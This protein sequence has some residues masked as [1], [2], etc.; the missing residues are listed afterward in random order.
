MH[1]AYSVIFFTWVSGTG[2]GLIIFAGFFS[3]FERALQD[4]FTGLV[5]IFISLVLITVG[6]FSSMFHL[7]H[8]ERAWRAL[9]QWRSSW[10]SREGLL[11]IATYI[12]AL[13]FGYGWGI[14]GC[15]DGLWAAAALITSLSA[16][17]TL[18]TTAMIYRSL[19]PIPAWNTNLTVVNYLLL[20]PMT[21]GLWLAAILRILDQPNGHIETAVS[22]VLIAALMSKLR[23]WQV[24]AKNAF[25]VRSA[26]AIG[27]DKGTIRSVEWPHTE[28]NYVLKEMGYRVGRKHSQILRRLTIALAFVV[29]LV[30]FAAAHSLFGWT[31]TVLVLVAAISGSMGV[32]VERWL[33]FAEANHTV[34]TY[35]YMDSM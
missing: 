22:L 34:S 31:S 13:V 18:Y 3:P 5:I 35:Y 19:T 1:P 8:P 33:F 14:V 29:P 24:I 16:T 25:V 21:G 7:G 28:Q 26:S 15:L 27:L 17:A 32:L 12:P 4:S 6:L 9:S 10:L 2:Y 30:S 23:Y 20:G 11:A